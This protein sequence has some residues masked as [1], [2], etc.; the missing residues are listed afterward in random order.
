MLLNRRRVCRIT[1]VMR[2]SLLQFRSS[3]HAA[4][5]RCYRALSCDS[6][7]NILHVLDIACKNFFKKARVMNFYAQLAVERR[8]SSCKTQF[9]PLRQDVSHENARSAY[10]VLRPMERTQPAEF[11]NW[12]FEVR[13]V[14]LLRKNPR[15]YA[16]RAFSCETPLVAFY[17]AL[18]AHVPRV[19]IVCVR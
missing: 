1:M 2:S 5:C 4:Q 17:C 6:V 18:F 14:C 12:C 7:A 19:R 15:G 8:P 16:L 11:V 3:V 10:L 9:S 13:K